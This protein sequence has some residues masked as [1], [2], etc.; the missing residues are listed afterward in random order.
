MVLWIFPVIQFQFF[1][2]SLILSDWWRAIDVI[3]KQTTRQFLSGLFHHFPNDPPLINCDFSDFKGQWFNPH[4]E[5][6][7]CN[8]RRLILNES[9]RRAHFRGWKL[10]T[11]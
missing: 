1:P 6:E 7:G 11:K 9:D 2:M 5:T 3:S 8:R 10:T 4:G